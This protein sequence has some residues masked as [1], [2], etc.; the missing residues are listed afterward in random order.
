MIHE[1]H[2]YKWEEH[3]KRKHNIPLRASAAI[4]SHRASFGYVISGKT[5]EFHAL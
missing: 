2:S 3:V 4:I 1:Q 5:C